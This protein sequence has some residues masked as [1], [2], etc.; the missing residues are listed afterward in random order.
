MFVGHYDR[1]SSTELGA[2]GPY[3]RGKLLG[4]TTS[5]GAIAKYHPLLIR[6]TLRACQIEIEPRHTSFLQRENF[7]TFRPV[8]LG[9]KRGQ[10]PDKAAR[11]KHYK[12]RFFKKLREAFSAF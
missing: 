6:D 2:C 1:S 3:V 9:G 5:D 11:R 12:L 8:P 4:E 10:H 7:D